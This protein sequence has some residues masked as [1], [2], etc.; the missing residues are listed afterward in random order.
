MIRHIPRRI[1]LAMGFSVGTRWQGGSRPDDSTYWRPTVMPPMLA[2]YS[3]G[4]FVDNCA[5]MLGCVGRGDVQNRIMGHGF[6]PEAP[7]LD[8]YGT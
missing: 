3:R 1:T 5:M 7:T 2:G 4:C 6:V 8:K